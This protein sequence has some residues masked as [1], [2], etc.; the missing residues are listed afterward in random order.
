[1]EDIKDFEEYNKL[2][3]RLNKHNLDHK[4]YNLLVEKLNIE[5][6]NIQRKHRALIKSNQYIK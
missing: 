3:E 4:N 2:I 6:E 5:I 1:M